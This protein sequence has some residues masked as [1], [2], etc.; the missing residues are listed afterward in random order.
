MLRAQHLGR[1][2]REKVIV[3]D[4]SFELRS[5]ET[6]GILGPSGSGKSSLLRL[7]NRLDEPTSGTVFLEGRDYR[8]IAPAELRRRVGLVMQRP[9]LFPGAVAGNVRFGPE[10]RGEKMSSEAISALLSQTGLPQYAARDVA[11]L[12]GGEAQRVSIARALANS[13]VVLLLDEPTSSLDDASK[14][15]IELLIRTIVSQ[16]RLGCVLVT[17]DRA[18][19]DRMTS[20]ILHM[21]GGRVLGEGQSC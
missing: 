12:S 10:Q 15:G 2:V 6:L 14:N 3:E 17:H 11:K 4:I 21:D 5:G 9:Y 20:R 19:A 8:D 1:K 7:L 13:P 18:Q 16:T